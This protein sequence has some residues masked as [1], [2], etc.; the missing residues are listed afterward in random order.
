MLTRAILIA[1]LLGTSACA[2]ALIGAGGVIIADQ[3]AEDQ[4]GDLF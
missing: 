1:A 4:G 2:P 3:V